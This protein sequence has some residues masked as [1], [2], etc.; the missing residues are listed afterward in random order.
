[1]TWGRTFTLF[2]FLPDKTWKRISFQQNSEL[3]YDRY[4]SCERYI[5]ERHL[6]VRYSLD[7]LEE[8]LDG[9]L[10]L[11]KEEELSTDTETKTT[12]TT[13]QSQLV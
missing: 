9:M 11:L 12:V 13:W 2:N 5:F 6:P 4:C 7:S 8:L 10:A 1:M 3:L